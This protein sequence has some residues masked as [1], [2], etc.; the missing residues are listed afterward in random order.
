MAHVNA[1][2]KAQLRSISERM[3][4]TMREMDVTFNVYRD[5]KEAQPST[6]NRR[7]WSCDILPHI[8]SKEDWDLISCG[9][10]Q[11][12][13]AFELFLRDIYGP[14]EILR[15]NAIPLRPVLGS[16]SYL[17]AALGVPASGGFYLHLCGTVL[18]R[19]EDGRWM[20]KAHQFTR[21]S[22]IAYMMQ[23]RRILARVH[24]EL[25]KERPIASIADTPLEILEQLQTLAPP[26]RTDFTAVL[27]TPGPGSTV[28]S[29]HSFLA[30]RMGLQ[31]VVGGDLIVLDDKV[32]MKVV[33]GLE[34]VK[35]IYN[36]LAHEY[37]DPLV[38]R[39]DSLIGVPGLIHCIR[40]GTVALVNSL[41][42][43]LADDRALLSFA[44][45]II[46]FYL[47]E[48]PI[49][50]T[51]PT[52]WLGD[53][54]Q[55]EMVLSDLSAYRI[56]R[57]T[58]EDVLGNWRGGLLTNRDEKL[59]RQELR[60]QPEAYVAQ[61]AFE[62]AATVCFDG[63]N[64]VNRSQDHVIFALR[65]GEEFEVIPGALTR[66][67][68]DLSAL[69]SFQGGG[70]SKDTWVLSG[71]PHEHE[72]YLPR[73]R[74]PMISARRITSRVAEASY[75]LGRYL[76]RLNSLCYMIQT[77]EG[78]ELEE[79]SAAERK[80]Y[81]PVW[82]RLLPPLES[83]AGARRSIGSAMDRYHLMFKPDAPGTAYALAASSMRN[84]ESIQEC[85][86]PEAW[87]IL[88][89]LRQVVFKSR[90]HPVMPE[91]LAVRQ[92]RRVSELVTRLIP[93]YFATMESTVL[94][95]ESRHLCVFG[96]MLERAIITANAVLAMQSALAEQAQR[97][98]A[99]DH[100]TEIELAAFLRLL[101]TRD[102]YRRVYQMRA[103][104]EQVLAILWSN[105]ETPRAVYYCLARCA[106]LLR[107]PSLAV[108]R[109]TA[110]TLE[111]IEG[112]LQLLSQIDW[113][114]YLTPENTVLAPRDPAKPRSRKS[115]ALG[116]LLSDL[117]ASLTSI[118]GTA[119]DGFL[120][121]HAFF[122]RP[123]QPLLEGFADAV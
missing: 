63:P 118:H 122:A 28:Y 87:S 32:Y 7:A 11:R 10:R 103:Q 88:A 49:L 12:L 36:R 45:K 47:G 94:A 16:P 70:G 13:R 6:P 26:N 35:L 97:S 71:A 79:L 41:G 1:L 27:L 99:F 121:H 104:P 84:A 74:E 44:P 9:L 31:L 83:P 92:T 50:P 2:P 115:S 23:N 57:L 110:A 18:M 58:G 82:S 119:N 19:G 59:I 108:A 106:A 40:K 116:S 37:L 89:E 54:D 113:G 8:F 56:R 101:G 61:P 38:C 112:L 42:C 24:P 21:S 77:I 107:E 29:E 62:G 111:S 76:E 52:Y 22:G 73:G 93:Q 14:K 67:S 5:L 17:H 96:Q 55:L 86:T 66:V 80:I 117:Y 100:A 69:T 90:Y 43:E 78:L 30:R 81:K 51:L 39:R 85:L 33:G 114:E 4:A 120:S 3:Q 68:S 48:A 60:R 46:R 109:G 53:I 102:A 95:D 25:F 105:P 34:Q 98:S 65:R 20:V 64:R 123:A 15:Q 75:W 91:P 72:A